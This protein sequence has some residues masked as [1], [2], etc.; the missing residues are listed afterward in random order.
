MGGP[1][2]LIWQSNVP[3]RVIHINIL[4]TLHQKVSPIIIKR[5]EQN[6]WN[7]VDLDLGKGGEDGVCLG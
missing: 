5:T 3:I 2:S 7:P 4:Y 1:I 6:I